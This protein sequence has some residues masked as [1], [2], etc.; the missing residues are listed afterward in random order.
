MDSRTSKERERIRM[1]QMDLEAERE[2]E[3]IAEIADFLENLHGNNLI[4]GNWEDISA[5]NLEAED[6][7]EEVELDLLSQEED[8][9][10]LYAQDSS[11]E[12]ELEGLEEGG[13]LER[14]VQIELLEEDLSADDE[15]AELWEIL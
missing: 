11:D 4:Y 1:E 9:L 2:D 3:V 15:N 7:D 6:E 13:Q 14:G 10:E 12:V 5:A 8:E